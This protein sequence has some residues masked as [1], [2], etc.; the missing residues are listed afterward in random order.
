MSKEKA[1]ILSRLVNQSVEIITEKEFTERINAGEK[2][3]HYIGF[4]ISGYVHIGQGIMSAL[5]MK[6]LTDL[7]VKC[8]VWLA[9]WHSAINEKLDGTAET[10]ARIGKG[11]FTEAIKACFIA[12]GGDPKKLEFRLASEWYTKGPMKYW[13]TVMAVASH[14]TMSRAV[15]S[16]DIMGREEGGDIEVAKLLYPTMQVADVYFQDIDIAHAGTDQ[17]KAYVI[18]RDVA[19][20][21]TQKESKPIILLHNL[22]PRLDGSDLKMSKSNPDGA[23]FV[24]DTGEEIQRKV[25]KAYAPEKDTK[26]N[27]V[28]RWT[29]HLLFWNRSGPF[30]IERKPEHGGDV[31]F[32]TF[33][34]LEKAYAT[35]EIHPMDLKATVAKELIALLKPVRDHFARP[36]VATKKAEL[37]N[38][39]KNR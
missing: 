2:L 25:N 9:D 22:L 15:R 33:E 17:R 12:V 4:E 31:E 34:E 3:T 18:A 7:G 38:L 11:Y 36:E 32:E 37:D 29:E 16:I 39:L 23:I 35:G 26:N 10:A 8:T 13:E 20:K 14:T 28:L 6:D 19:E 30:R 1:E 27:P 5:V 24:H 21:I